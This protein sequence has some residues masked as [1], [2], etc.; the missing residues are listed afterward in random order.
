MN[1]SRTTK[2]KQI[3][4]FWEPASTGD[5][6]FCDLPMAR[7]AEL[8]KVLSDLLLSAAGGDANV[9]GGNDGVA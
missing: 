3:A 8:V 5:L 2:D 1:Q 6:I 9:K 4:L 7:V